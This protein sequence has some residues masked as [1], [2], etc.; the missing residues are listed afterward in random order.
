V[1]DAQWAQLIPMYIAIRLDSATVAEDSSF[2]IWLIG[3]MISVQRYGKS[4]LVL[5]NLSHK[6]SS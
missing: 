5:P 2:L 6:N 3:L 4:L 1:P